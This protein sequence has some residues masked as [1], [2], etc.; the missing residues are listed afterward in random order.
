MRDESQHVW[1]GT[2]L[3]TVAGIGVCLVV[4]KYRQ[5]ILHQFQAILRYK[6]PLRHQK[7][8]IVSTIDECRTLMRNMKS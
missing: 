7:I 2:A 8:E 5:Q 6:N 1:N 4:A 3:A